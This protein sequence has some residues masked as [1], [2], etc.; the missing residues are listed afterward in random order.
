MAPGLLKSRTRG[1]RKWLNDDDYQAGFTQ[2]DV[3]A[4]MGTA[5][6][7][8]FLEAM[9][10]ALAATRTAKPPV[11]MAFV[12][13]PNGYH[14]GRLEPGLRRPARGALPRILKPLEPF[15][16]GYS[17][18]WQ[19]DSQCRARF[20]G[21][22]RRSRPLQCFVPDRSPSGA[23]PLVDIKAGVSFDQIVAT[24]RGRTRAFPSLELGMEDAR[25]AG[26]C[27]SGYSCAY[28]NNLAWGK[29]DSTASAGA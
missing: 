29:R 12:Y 28:T 20:V 27:D 2:T 23:K 24:G 1:G 6:A 8:P 17:P 5:V 15:R 19:S 18:A 25:Q 13:V 9:V 7:L 4:G 16:A 11:R 3:P 14:H 21:W 10:P 22:R 26:D